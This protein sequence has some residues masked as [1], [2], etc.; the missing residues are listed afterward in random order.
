VLADQ[1]VISEHKTHR[2]H[3]GAPPAQGGKAGPRY[4]PAAR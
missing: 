3:H 4:E 1:R 2:C